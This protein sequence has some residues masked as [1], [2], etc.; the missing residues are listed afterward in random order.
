MLLF[1]QQ[2]CTCE[3]GF[4]MYPPVYTG[5]SQAISPVGGGQNRGDGAWISDYHPFGFSLAEFPS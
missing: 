2:D 4:N 5:V 3:G 1:G